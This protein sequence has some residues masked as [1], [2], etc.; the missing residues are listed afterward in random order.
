MFS[1]GIP[2]PAVF[3]VQKRIQ[4]LHSYLDPMYEREQQHT[5]I[6]VAIKLYEDGKIDGLEHV[7]IMDGV[8]VTQDEAFEGSAWVWSEGVYYQLAQKFAYND[9]PSGLRFS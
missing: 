1:P 6:K 4:T 2:T 7:Y 3:D 5:N 9:R 8:V